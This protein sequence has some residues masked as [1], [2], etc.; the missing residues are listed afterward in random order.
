MKFKI[1]LFSVLCLS[2]F[3]VITNAQAININTVPSIQ[4]TGKAEVKAAPDIAVFSLVVEKTDMNLQ[5]AKIQNDQSVSQILAITQKYEIPQKDVKTD[6]I[7]VSKDYET[8]R[9]EGRSKQVFQGFQVSKTVIIRLTDISKFET[10]YSELLTT[11][12]SR[13]NRVSFQTSEIRKYKDEARLLA[14]K[15]AREKAVAIAGG[16]GQKVG[17]AIKIDVESDKGYKPQ[18][19]SNI[20]TFSSNDSASNSRTLALGMITISA[21][22]EVKF[23]LD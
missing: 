21:E 18:I 4:V 17:K 3:A 22:V 23:L 20:A 1:F 8:V 7:S 13:A 10:M 5:K 19:L 11:G 12:I 9:E 15:A 6:Y 16:L 14:V 2:V